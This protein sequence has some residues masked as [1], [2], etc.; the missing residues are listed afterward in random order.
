[1]ITIEQSR[2]RATRILVWLSLINLVSYA[3]RNALFA[4]YPDLAA[5]YDIDYAQIGFL[6]TVFMIPHAIATLPFGWAGDAYDRRKVIAFGIGLASV[7]AAIGA[8]GTSYITLAT[9]RALVGLGTAAVV[10]VANSILGQLYTANKASRIAVFNL[11]LFLGGVVGFGAGAALGFPLVVIVL[12]VPGIALA[13]VIVGQPIASHTDVPP[14]AVAGVSVARYLL[15]F[16]RSFVGEARALLRIRTLRWLML[17][18]TAMAFAAGGYNAFMLEYL[19]SPTGKGMSEAAATNVLV[20]GLFGALAGIIVGG[21]AADALR[22]RFETGRLWMIAIGMAAS[23]P[24][25]SLAIVAPPNIAIYVAGVATLFTFS[26]Y[27]APMAATVDDLAPPGKSVAAQGLVIGVMHL[28][29]TAPSSWVLGEIA[30][31]TDLTTAMWI[32][33]G[34]LAVAAFAMM[35]ATRTFAADRQTK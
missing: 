30:V 2:A 7:A 12:A 35:M 10:P 27:H 17:S 1:M 31:R 23:I 19:K 8:I 13:A 28:V 34:I 18:T 21:R 16:T 25:A 20:V 22:K 32:P 26:L 29:G 9:S 14:A 5:R 3:G 6:Q 11:G 24:T 15:G 4:V 33:T